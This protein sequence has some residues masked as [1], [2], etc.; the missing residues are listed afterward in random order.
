MLYLL[1]L[2]VSNYLYMF[3]FTLFSCVWDL[4]DWGFYPS[5]LEE[6]EG[7]FVLLAALKNYILKIQQQWVFPET[8]FLVTV[9]NPQSSLSITVSI[10]ATNWGNSPYESEL[11][12]DYLE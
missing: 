2:N 5:S 7:S 4:L 3:S 1:Y 12:V 10:G 8:M 9:D 6:N 11:S